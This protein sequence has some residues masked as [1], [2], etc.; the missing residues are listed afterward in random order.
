MRRL[1]RNLSNI[2]KKIE[3]NMDFHPSLIF[4]IMDNLPRHNL[5]FNKK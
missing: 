4:D 1:T 3:D 2:V 5:D